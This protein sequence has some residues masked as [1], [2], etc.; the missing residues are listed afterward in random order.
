M[1]GVILS[2][3][4]IDQVKLQCRIDLKQLFHATKKRERDRF[5]NK[6]EAFLESDPCNKEIFK[7]RLAKLNQI[8]ISGNNHEKMSVL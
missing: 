1:S 2:F 8:S 7:R 4:Q 6:W 3:R 5:E